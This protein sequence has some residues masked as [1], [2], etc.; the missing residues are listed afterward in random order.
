MENKTKTC[1]AYCTGSSCLFY[2]ND[3]FRYELLHIDKTGFGIIKIWF[4]NLYLTTLHNFVFANQ[5]VFKLF[6]FYLVAV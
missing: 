2:R 4:C 3:F 1:V 5:T 6:D